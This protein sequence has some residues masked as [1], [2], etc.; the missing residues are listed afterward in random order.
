MGWGSMA[1]DNGRQR[2]HRLLWQRSL[3]SPCF[4]SPRTWR[5]SLPASGIAA[6]IRDALRLTDPKPYRM[7]LLHRNAGATRGLV[8]VMDGRSGLAAAAT[9]VLPLY[10][11]QKTNVSDCAASGAV[12]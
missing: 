9:T 2:C 11:Q 12:Q 3:G 4:P 6:G 10:T 5:Y 1:L 7:R 8:W